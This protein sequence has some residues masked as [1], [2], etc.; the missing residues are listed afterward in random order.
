[1]GTISRRPTAPRLVRP[2]PTHPR[3]VPGPRPDRRWHPQCHHL[4]R[5]VRPR[6]RHRPGLGPPLQ[7]AGARELDL[8]PHRQS[9]PLFAPTQAERIVEAV[10]DSEPIDHGLPGHGWTLKK[11]R[12]WIEAT[13]GRQ[14]G[15]N[16]IRRILGKAGLTW[17]KIKKLLGKA[18]AP[19]RA[20][21]IVTL[22]R[23]FERVRSESVSLIYI[24]ESHFHQ[25]LDGGYTWSE[26]GKPAWRRS[27]SPGHSRRLDWYGAYDFTLGRCLI[28]EDG[29]CD[30]LRTCQFLDQV[31]RWHGR[32]AGRIV[33]IWD[34][35]SWHTSALVKEHAEMLG[36]EL[37][38]LP[39]YSPDLNPIEGLWAWM[40]EEVTRGHCHASVKALR[41]A[42]QEFIARINGD[43][44]AMVDRLWPKF[45]LDPEYE[46]KLLV[47]A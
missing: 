7:S 2:P 8:P 33:V 42:C 27:T 1:V 21:H 45:E 20:E 36:I 24:D 4:G 11:L 39:T 17:K 34:N 3:A 37:V 12:Q 19:A 14:V 29:R 18:N 31:V 9:P 46:A 5:T 32:G 30:G 38:A 47:S 13:L 25:D 22:E 23:L 26:K 16:A 43:A 40:R 44:M 35:A 10:R 28:W 15:R 6:G 41:A